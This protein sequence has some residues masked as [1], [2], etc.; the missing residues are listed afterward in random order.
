MTK[1]YVVFIEQPAV[2]NAMK[3]TATYIKQYSMMDWLEWH[4]DFCNRFHVVHKKTG[5][6]I[7]TEF[8]SFAAFY[9]VGILNAYEDD[10]N[11][12]VV[13]CIALPN[14]DI[15]KALL[16]ENLLSPEE[17]MA[18]VHSGSIV[19]YIVPLIEE[20]DDTIDDGD[21]YIEDYY[22]EAQAIRKG[23]K[24]VLIP[25]VICVGVDFAVANKNYV[26]KP[27]K[28][29]YGMSTY[30]RKGADNEGNCVMK[31]DLDTQKTEIW[32]GMEGQ[33]PSYPIFIPNPD[34]ES[35]DD[36]VLVFGL[37]EAGK[38]NDNGNSSNSIVFLDAKSFT[39]IGRATFK[40]RIVAAWIHGMF[41]KDKSA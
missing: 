30:A 32:S 35:E 40:D 5:E 34:P 20:L 2:I 41:L 6:V 23:D 37:T 14:T 24:V 22:D 12:L 11:N 4:P 38:T 8:L 17:S 3:M 13:D 15:M 36:G 25:E 26:G 19:R 33:I 31:V 7:K 27:Y 28:Y 21:N 1:N 10:N 16:I 29:A 9:G 18:N 39:E